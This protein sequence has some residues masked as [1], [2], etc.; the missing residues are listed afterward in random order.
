M[1]CVAISSTP[2]KGPGLK[3]VEESLPAHDKP[4]YKNSWVV[5]AVVVHP[6]GD[7]I[8]RFLSLALPFFYI[9]EKV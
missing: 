4:F 1:Y 2:Y 8:R 9:L 7:L 6:M 5:E 3:P